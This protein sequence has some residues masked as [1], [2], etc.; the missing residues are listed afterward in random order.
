MTLW[1]S[2]REH[3]LSTCWNVSRLSKPDK[4]RTQGVTEGGRR[5]IKS[6]QLP[7]PRRGFG[8]WP[9]GNG[10]LELGTPGW[11]RS[12]VESGSKTSRALRSVDRQTARSSLVSPHSDADRVWL[13]QPVVITDRLCLF[14]QLFS[15]WTIRINQRW[16]EQ[17]LPHSS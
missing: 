6:C 12:R 3:H 2:S 16:R 5:P 13:F 15:L 11:Q 10:E 1:R 8:Q 7:L 9:Y 17:R 14:A 4:R